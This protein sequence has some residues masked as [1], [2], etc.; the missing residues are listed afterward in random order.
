MLCD[1]PIFGHNKENEKIDYPKACNKLTEIV[2]FLESLHNKINPDD[3]KKDFVIYNLAISKNAADQKYTFPFIAEYLQTQKLSDEEKKNNLTFFK[4]AIIAFINDLFITYEISLFEDANKLEQIKQIIAEVTFVFENYVSK[5]EKQWWFMEL[6]KQFGIEINKEGE[7]YGVAVNAIFSILN[8]PD[9]EFRARWL[10]ALAYYD[11]FKDFDQ[12]PEAIKKSEI[13]IKNL[14]LEIITYQRTQYNIIAGK[15]DADGVVIST[16]AAKV[17]TKILP[18]II[19]KDIRRI[20]TTIG[21]Y[22]VA[23]LEKYFIELQNELSRNNYDGKIAIELMANDHAIV[24]DF[25]T[26]KKIWSLIDANKLPGLQFATTEIKDFANTLKNR[27]T[28]TPEQKANDLIIHAR[29]FCPKNEK[30]DIT[31]WEKSHNL[32]DAQFRT[33]LPKLPTLMHLAIC[34]NDCKMILVLL[35]KINTL[36][37][38]TKTANIENIQ[39][40]LDFIFNWLSSE[41]K[42]TETNKQ[43]IDFCLNNGANPLKSSSTS[44]ETFY[45]SISWLLPIFDMDHFEVKESP[46]TMAIKAGNAA[47]IKQL[48]DHLITKKTV[49][50]RLATKLLDFALT[51]DFLTKIENKNVRKDII[52]KFLQIGADPKA[53][54]GNGK[55]LQFYV[56]K[57]CHENF[58]PKSYSAF[59]KTGADKLDD[60]LEKAAV[61][62]FDFSITKIHF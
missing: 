58:D 57:L 12:I 35:E 14:L 24:V 18:Q 21:I 23:E 39:F 37:Q 4:Q 34:D 61:T 26:A 50:P 38:V 29:V 31:T 43:I 25:D 59:F 20:A 41:A 6:Q 49:V 27:L 3:C 54:Y 46:L 32:T 16:S 53:E 7:C 8:E 13:E 45:K 33:I 56:N 9:D 42:I 48:L 55:S 60:A 2:R 5:K 30:L 47:T 11:L 15:T 1:Y 36:D 19:L 62:K 22:S 44:W 52:T 28:F 51:N 17:N 10:R 40:I